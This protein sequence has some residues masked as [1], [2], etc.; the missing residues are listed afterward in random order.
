MTQRKATGG[1]KQANNVHSL[2][3]MIKK[4]GDMVDQIKELKEQEQ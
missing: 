4:Q 3:N 1:I 2:M